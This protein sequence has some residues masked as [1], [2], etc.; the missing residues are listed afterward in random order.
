MKRVAP[1]TDTGQIISLF[2]GLVGILSGFALSFPS[3]TLQVLTLN[4]H[5]LVVGILTQPLFR[6]RVSATTYVVNSDIEHSRRE[7]G[8]GTGS[9]NI[10]GRRRQVLLGRIR[11]CHRTVKSV[12]M[13]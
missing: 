10:R 6:T 13:P 2:A 9:K 1:L 3:S 4:I 11:C 7:F 12:I 5:S 8:I